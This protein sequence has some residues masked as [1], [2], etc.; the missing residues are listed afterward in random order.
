MVA[1]VSVVDQSFLDSAPEPARHLSSPKPS[2]TGAGSQQREHDLH[3]PRVA[4][5]ERVDRIVQRTIPRRAAQRLALRLVPRSPRDHRGPPH[6]LKTLAL[7]QIMS[8]IRRTGVGRAAHLGTHPDTRNDCSKLRPARRLGH[9]ADQNVRPAHR[10]SRTDPASRA[11]S[12]APV[13]HIS[14]A[15]WQ[16]HDLIGPHEFGPYEVLDNRG[17]GSTSRSLIRWR[18][19]KLTPQ[20]PACRAYNI[21]RVLES[22]QF[23]EI[24][25]RANRIAHETFV[26]ILRGETPPAVST[27]DGTVT[28]TREAASTSAPR[29]ACRKPPWTAFPR[30]S[31]RSRSSSPTSCSRLRPTSRCST[32]W[33][34]SC[35]S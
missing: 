29:S 21:E 20:R 19:E 25:V 17:A 23:A 11:W 15:P 35:S 5:A 16:G 1:A 3:R 2:Q 28:L 4:V 6:R 32:S 12:T 14:R 10:F 33:P 31:G 8:P 24:W 7:R 27:A 30:A 18:H 34:G 13:P 9:R 22:P 26:A